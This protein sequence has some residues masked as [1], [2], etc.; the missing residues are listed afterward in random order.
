MFARSLADLEVRSEFVWQNKGESS[1][2]R[3]INSEE[4]VAV[5]PE[6]SLGPCP[7]LCSLM[8]E[9]SIPSR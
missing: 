8:E 9:T 3:A 2:Q 7:R 6:G 5:Q 1:L 4:G